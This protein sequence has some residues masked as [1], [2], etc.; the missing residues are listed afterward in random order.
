L[1]AALAVAGLSIAEGPGRA[2]IAQRGM[3]GAAPR[4]TAFYDRQI[5]A[6]ETM[7]SCALAIAQE[8]TARGIHIDPE[9]D[10]NGTGLI[11]AEF[12]D[13]TTTVGV[14]EAK[15]TSTNPAFAALMVRYF[16]EAG[17]EPG[18]VV[19]V[20][21]S[22]SFPALILATLAACRELDLRPTVVYSIGASMYGANIPDFTFADM[23]VLLNQRDLLPYELAAVSLGGEGDAGGNGILG[24]G[25]ECFE[26]AA[27]RSEAP[28]LKEDTIADSVRRRMEVFAKAAES[29]GRPV[30]CFV[31]VGGA[32]ANYGNTAASLDFPNGLVM[33]PTVMSAH[34][35]RGLIFEYAAMGVPV[36]NLL[37]ARGLAIRNGLPVDP[38]PLP[39]PGEGGVYFTTAHSRPAAAAAL[40][41]SAVVALAAAGV[42]RKGRYGAP[43]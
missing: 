16:L 42:L 1:A 2:S 14:L 29:F 3:S 32:T 11:G 12:T 13:I 8:R 41:T 28:V 23:L 4:T 37:D 6:A 20:G 19:A 31:N 22:G 18:D 17:L 24:Q 38:V 25:A 15:R 26:Q 5:R 27:A 40:L 34:P 33:H 10:P 39:P 7:R 35:E 9:L 30:A 21:A 43:A 36:I